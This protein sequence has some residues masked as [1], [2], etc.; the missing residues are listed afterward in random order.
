[1]TRI[2]R[3]RHPSQ[4]RNA[5][6]M[7]MSEAKRSSRV[8]RLHLLAV[9]L[10]AVALFGWGCGDDAKPLI[11]LHAWESDSHSLNN[12]L[13]KFIV[14]NGYGYPVEVVVQATPVLM[15]T[16]PA[17]EIDL[18]LEGWQQNIPDWYAEH[19]A[20]GS[21]VNLGMNFEGGP[22]FYMVPK[23]VA[24]E[25]AIRSV[26]D[27][28]DHW[29][30]FEDPEDPSKG[31]FYSG[32]MGWQASEI[33]KVKIQ[34]YGLDPFFNALSPG[35]APALEAAFLGAQQRHQP[36]VGYYWSP[37]SLMGLYEWQIL[38][39]PPHTTECWTAISAA[40]DDASLRPVDRACSYPDSTLDKLAHKSF[41]TKA[42]DVA[43]MVRQ[44]SVG[45]NPLVQTLAW[46]SENAKNDWERAAVYYLRTN[47]S[48]WRS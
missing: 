17:G 3:V 10:L 21:I 42:P 36:V 24:D 26:T 16:L 12:A 35:S 29:R 14:E 7:T 40:A 46:A 39:E 23:W 48:R 28:K 9:A 41:L 32:I 1:M 18:T 34:G 5:A 25:Y 37:T 47:E 11:R 4:R 33:N 27:L 31:V 19:A 2:D 13:F 44:M 43:E 8:I 15:E 20:S 38:E 30:L 6:V 45:L 22:Q